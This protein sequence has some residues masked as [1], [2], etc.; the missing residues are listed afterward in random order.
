M[1]TCNVEN[2]GKLCLAKGLCPRHY[3]QQKIFGHVLK[4]SKF[5]P[6][7]IIK[8]EDHAEVIMFNANHEEIARALIDLENIPLIQQFKWFLDCST[9]Y[10]STNI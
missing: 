3:H 6:N 8:Y 10:P 2:C 1:N 4:R 7:E 5:D 9:G